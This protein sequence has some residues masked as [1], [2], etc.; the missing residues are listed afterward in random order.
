MKRRVAAGCIGLALCFGFGRPESCLAR[1]ST[2][3]ETEGPRRWY[4]F[5]KP[6]RETPAEQLEYARTLRAR[7]SWRTDRHYRALVASW[8]TSPEAREALMERA[9]ALDL[10]G[11]P[12]AASKAY[13]EAL[14][15][16][17]ADESYDQIVKR[18]Y[19]IAQE[20]LQYKAARWFFGGFPAPE[21]AVP[22]LESVLKAAPRA[23]FAST[24][25]YQ[26]AE[27]YEL[28]GDF[29]MALPSY[30]LVLSLY[31]DSGW[32]REAAFHR[33]FVLCD[34]SRKAPNDRKLSED[35]WHALTFLLRR[36]PEDANREQA[37]E[38]LDVVQARRIRQ[39]YRVALYYDRTL[40]RPEA[41]I[42]TYRLFL[43]RFPDA[44]QV[45]EARNR[46]AELTERTVGKEGNP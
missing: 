7:N 40:K 44:P 14:D 17:P 33:A 36:Y 4:T 46:L 1:D 26:I 27:A 29:E 20:M 18:Q 28:S 5:L 37:L 38:R 22:L 31:P 32:A 45:E 23:P 35:A 3:R 39:D 41:A 21:R 30:G 13:A 11:K 15:R 34:L 12:E 8:P 2:Y 25:Q 42:V 10:R 16:L 24:A 9:R 6:A 43:S 19:E